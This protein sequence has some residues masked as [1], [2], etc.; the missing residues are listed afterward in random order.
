MRIMQI[1][2]NH[3]EA[4][5]DLLRQTVV[6]KEV[7]LVLLSEPY[8]RA[9]QGT[10]VTDASKKAA[11]W[12]PGPIAL[13]DGDCQHSGFVRATAKYI[14][15]YSCY[16]LPSWTQSEFQSMLD[17]LVADAREKPS[18]LIAG[19]FNAWA[20]EWDSKA[21]NAR[22]RS[23]LEAFAMLKVSLLNDGQRDT[24]RKAG[25]GSKVDLTFVSDSLVARCKWSLSEEY[26]NSDHQAIFLDIASIEDRGNRWNKTTGPR[27]RDALF[28]EDVFNTIMDSYVGGDGTAG[29]LRQNVAKL[30][31][32]ACDAAM[33][34]R[35]N[36][37]RRGSPCHWWTEEI[38]SLRAN[39]L[40]A[41]R[42]VQR[43]RGRE[44]F[45]ELLLLYR[46]LRSDL[47]KA[48]RAIK[49]RSFEE[50]CQDA[51]INP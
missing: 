17:E 27:W 38:A 20:F 4:A 39:C 31:V 23:L 7:D 28:D 44:N 21:C 42:K 25:R 35:R 9:S 33:P 40:K 30:L 8:R 29:E 6:E 41:R 2:L 3:G 50:I 16:A 10:W 49:R 22:G 37:R 48:I 51:D 43:S 34:R 18:V 11:I 1:N 47:K 36:T 12:A 24:F 26:T 15:C 32:Q 5:H 46:D 14:C 45:N 13:L 19:D